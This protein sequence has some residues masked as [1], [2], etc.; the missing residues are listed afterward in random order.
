VLDCAQGFAAWTN[1]DLLEHALLNLT[2]NAV[3]HTEA[4]EIRVSAH[5]EGDTVTIEV[6]DTGPGIAPE[7]IGRL[8]DRFYRGP[9]EKGRAGVGLGLPITKDAV[10]ALGGRVEID[11]V[12]GVGTT[13]RV[14][15]PHAVMPVSA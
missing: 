4:G 13:A 2:G 9:T 10:E 1:P 12:L 6:G 14:V 15:L 7:E 3:H 8:F 11:S 5:A